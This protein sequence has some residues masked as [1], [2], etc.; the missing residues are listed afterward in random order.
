MLWNFPGNSVWAAGEA[1]PD[2]QDHR[3]SLTMRNMFR[4]A[5]CA[6]VFSA[7]PA[8]A[9]PIFLLNDT[10]G[11]GVGTQQ[12]AGFEAA[13]LLWSSLFTDNV[14]IRLDVGYK[15]LGT[16]I[17]GQAGSSS[18]G[19]LYND[20]RLALGRD[21]KSTTD[22]S[23]YA[24]LP[25][26]LTFLSNEAG[27]CTSGSKCQPINPASRTLDKDGTFDNKNL[28][29][30]T[31]NLKALGLLSSA[32]T[33]RDASLTF[34]SRFNW[35]Y[36]G[37]NGI[38]GGAYDFVGVAA[39]EIGHALGFVS[40]VDLVDYNVGETGLDSIGWG[41]VLDLFRFTGRSRDWTV[42]GSPCVSIDKGVSCV[43]GLAT[44]SQYGDGQQASHW[45]DGLGLGLMDPTAGSGELLRITSR[46][47][48]AFDAMGWDLA[49]GQ[50][51]GGVVAWTEIPSTDPIGSWK[52]ENIPAAV[53][54]PGAF[55]LFGL[56]ALA[57]ARR[58]RAR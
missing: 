49:P 17:L 3:G 47:K 32:G 1:S 56:G 42:G 37:S 30:N 38:T 5:L 29:A 25:Y 26:S 45:K 36:D 12:R 13:A 21:R 10:G 16:G 31:A 46:D 48:I 8:A 35:D 28:D 55:A 40:G 7:A 6:C 52:I 15:S 51:L 22:S 20:V 33:Q 4:A 23:A 39:H 11:V 44:G 2:T 43:G 53:P 34:S 57:I 18:A 14:T 19:V 27:N 24:S 58:R 50:A 9:A 54:A 41:S